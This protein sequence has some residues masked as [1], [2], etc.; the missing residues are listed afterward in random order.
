MIGIP[1]VVGCRHYSSVFQLDRQHGSQT[2][3]LHRGDD[4]EL[5]ERT[6][7]SCNSIV[8]GSPSTV[9]SRRSL[10]RRCWLGARQAGLDATGFKKLAAGP[11]TKVLADRQKQLVTSASH[12]CA[13]T[14]E[15]LAASYCLARGRD[16][17]EGAR[18]SMHACVCPNTVMIE[19]LPPC[20]RTRRCTRG[21]PRPLCG[22]LRE[23]LNANP[24]PWSQT[25]NVT[26]WSSDETTMST[27]P[28]P[29]V[30][31]FSTKASTAC[32][33]RPGFPSAKVLLLG[34]AHLTDRPFD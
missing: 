17:T 10:P 9:H 11:S 32:R 7:R 25:F 26:T 20:A 12:R 31:E 34:P 15:F 4:V 30:N 16:S 27:T 18:S 3:Q 13:V 23:S 6:P 8:T 5:V 28:R 24:G 19:S 21:K 2:K 33:R 14:A 1:S 29:W 22:G